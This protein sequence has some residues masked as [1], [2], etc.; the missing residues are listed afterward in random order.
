MDILILII[1]IAVG[2]IIGWL[3]AKVLRP[4]MNSE[5]DANNSVS[6]D[7]FNDLQNRLNSVLEEKTKVDDEVI[8]LS[9]ELS[10]W[11][12]R[13]EQMELRL[14]EQKGEI[15]QLQDKF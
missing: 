15:G 4:D 3:L 13:H 1:G 11:T 14:K 8:R 9:S 5:L 7:R 12:E 10:R 6:L 2:V